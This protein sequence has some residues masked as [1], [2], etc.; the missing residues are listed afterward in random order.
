M[1]PE[2]GWEVTTTND[3]DH[4]LRWVT[5]ATITPSANG[6]YIVYNPVSQNI[7]HV[8]LEDNTY[9]YITPTIT[10]DTATTT[11]GRLYFTEG[12]WHWEPDASLWARINEAAEA[13]GCNPTEW[14]ARHGGWDLAAAII[15]N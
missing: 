4:P 12:A 7:G 1:W 8:S 10:T 5:S 11:N 9:T 2:Q 6:N 14:I 13:E 15:K 3:E